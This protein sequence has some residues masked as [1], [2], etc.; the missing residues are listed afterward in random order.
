MS[1]GIEVFA[2]VVSAVA[3]TALT[4]L[5]AL[6]AWYLK[7][8]YAEHRKNTAVR[9]W[10]VGDPS[11]EEVDDAGQISEIETRFET[12]ADEMEAQHEH[13]A[14]ELDETKTLVERIAAQLESHPEH[15]FTRGGSSRSSGGSSDD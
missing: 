7:G 4:G 12:L 3:S 11:L 13:M 10:L 9:R 6:V 2:A 14:R 15:D 5:F 8:E 1:Y